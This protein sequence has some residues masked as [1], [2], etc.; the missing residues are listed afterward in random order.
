MK[1][2]TTK[3]KLPAIDTYLRILRYICGSGNADVWILPRYE[4]KQEDFDICLAAAKMDF[5]RWRE[6]GGVWENPWDGFIECASER[7]EHLRYARTVVKSGDG[8]EVPFGDPDENGDRPMVPVL[9]KFDCY[10]WSIV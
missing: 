5:R 6:R 1:I 9:Q 4:E 3:T 2:V 8:M 7:F 10:M